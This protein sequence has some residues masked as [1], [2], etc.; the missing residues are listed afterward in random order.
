MTILVS[1][2]LNAETVAVAD[3]RRAV[4]GHGSPTTDD[5][6]RK[7]IA[8]PSDEI[9]IALVGTLRLESSGSPETVLQSWLPDLAQLEPGR[10]AKRLC[11]MLGDAAKATG[12]G[13]QAVVTLYDRSAQGTV[14]QITVRCYE[15]TAA[16]ATATEVKLVEGEPL[17]MGACSSWAEL[18]PGR[19]V[20]KSVGEIRD[21]I[22]AYALKHENGTVSG[23]VN[24][25]VLRP[26]A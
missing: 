12:Q 19:E 7:V 13:E 1:M 21:A 2:L 22:R 18:A 26:T 25:I 20:P 4:G 8:D 23:E 16:E 3:K 6:A 24:Q 9:A 14:V 10:R 15:G 11:E 5:T 17:V